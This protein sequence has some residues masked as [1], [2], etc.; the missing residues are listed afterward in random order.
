VTSSEAS[1]FA[2]PPLNAGMKLDRGSGAGRAT[3]KAA[4]SSG[5]P[6]ISQVPR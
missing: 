3:L 4:T 1:A 2:A 5:S 6:T